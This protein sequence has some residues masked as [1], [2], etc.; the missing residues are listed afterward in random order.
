MFLYTRFR[1][2]L[3]IFLL[4]PS[5]T[6]ADISNRRET[7][8][9]VFQTYNKDNY[10]KC[11]FHIIAHYFS[12]PGANPTVK[13]ILGTR[14]HEDTS[15]VSPS[16][17]FRIHF[18]TADSNRPVL[19]DS[20]GQP[21]PNS[22]FAFVDSVAKICDYVYYVEVDSLGFP[23]PASDSGAGGGDQY[24][25]YIEALPTGEYGYTDWN[26]S[27][28]IIQ[29]ANPTYAT[30]TVI[31]NE[32]ESTYTQ[33]I[34]AMEVTIAHEFHHGIQVGNYGV[35]QNDLWFYEL[36]ST[37]MEQVVYPGVKDYYQYLPDFFDNISSMPFNSYE[38]ADF[39]G[40]E[41]CV[42]GI[43]VQDAY[44]LR[45]MKSIWQNMS[46]EQVMPAIEDAFKANGISPSSAFQLFSEWNYFTGYRAAL[47]AQFGVSSYPLAQYYP[48]AHLD[49]IG[50][51]SSTG[52]T[53][54]GEAL[55]LT[56]HFFQVNDG[57]DT[58]GIAVSNNNFPAAAGQDTTQFQFSVGISKNG[59]DCVRDLSNGFCLFFAVPDYNNWSLVPFIPENALIAA[60][61]TVFP[62]PFNPTIQ[63][64]KIPYPFPETNNASLSIY[65]ISGGLVDEIRG[66][67]GMVQYLRGRYFVWDG[68]SETG[69]KVGT[70]VYIYVVSD[71]S[72]SVV[73]KI[74]V[75]R[76]Q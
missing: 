65:D 68:T 35:W 73:G 71:G 72:K 42:F 15:I 50:A 28:P 32:F 22:M 27:A 39:A 76:N 45:V 49:G 20:D 40:Y 70:G 62:Q 10:N 36:T 33:G 55:R 58:I 37:W 17:K 11:G 41:R 52:V 56:E 25:I 19:Y 4:I 21:Q 60:R 5:A 43:F 74:A 44:G 75:V 66:D 3:I 18:D 12:L 26:P 53:F 1:T 69:R 59:A 57:S 48:L 30:W 8:A 14:P 51:L 61:N 47:G 16:G 64:V 46:R 23:P 63:K 9:H 67:I 6:L 38:P 13:S 24:D 54:S 29:R 2:V 34:P 31:R 7:V